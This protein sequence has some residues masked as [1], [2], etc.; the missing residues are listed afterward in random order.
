MGRTLIAVDSGRPRTFTNPADA[1]IRLQLMEFFIRASQIKFPPGDNPELD[2]I[3][4][5]NQ[6]FIELPLAKQ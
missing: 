4:K 1:L 3:K 2:S 6:T 5:F